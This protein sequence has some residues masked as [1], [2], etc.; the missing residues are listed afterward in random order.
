MVKN[1]KEFGFVLDAIELLRNGKKTPTWVKV[2]DWWF[3]TFIFLGWLTL[4]GFLVKILIDT[5]HG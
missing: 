5:F 2:V 3:A 1:Q 4:L